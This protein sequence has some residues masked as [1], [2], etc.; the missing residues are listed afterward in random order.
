[1]QNNLMEKNAVNKY[2]TDLI[3][4]LLRITC[5]STMKLKFIR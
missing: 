1:M 5:H 3:Y 4:Y 2:A